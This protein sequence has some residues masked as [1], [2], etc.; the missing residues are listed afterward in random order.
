M[1]EQELLAAAFTGNIPAPDAYAHETYSVVS[2]DG[3]TIVS[4]VSHAVALRTKNDYRDIFGGRY[5]IIED[6][7]VLADGTTLFDGN[8][9]TFSHV[10]SH[11]PED[12]PLFDV[13]SGNVLVAQNLTADAK[14]EIVAKIS[15]PIVI[16]YSPAENDAPAPA[17]SETDWRTTA[18]R[19]KVSRGTAAKVIEY[20]PL[21]VP[22]HM[23]EWTIV[24]TRTLLPRYA[25][26][27]QTCLDYLHQMKS[28][29]V[30]MHEM[31]VVRTADFSEYIW[32]VRLTGKKVFIRGE[33]KF[34]GLAQDAKNFVAHILRGHN[35]KKL[36]AKN[37][38][39]TDVFVKPQQDED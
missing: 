17:R 37:I 11:V 7:T 23:R 6:V 38:K 25:G 24:D 18:A 31:K 3:H 34:V 15:N 29:G 33:L 22:A 2:H 5:N 28:N 13:Y 19:R 1:M 21:T 10:P 8:A 35:D 27:K 32:D 14:N 26:T 30:K 36:F 9:E 39:V 4:G 12:V 16:K 20:R